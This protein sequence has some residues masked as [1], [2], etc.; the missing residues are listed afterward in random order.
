[1]ITLFDTLT[2]RTKKYLDY[3]DWVSIFK[4]FK[5]GFHYLPS[6]ENLVKRIVGQMNNNRLTNSGQPAT[7]RL[8]L[9]E[10][11]NKLLSL[12]SNYDVKEGKTW[13]ISKHKYL[14]EGKRKAVALVSSNSV[15]KTFNS[16][17]DCAKF[18]GVTTMTITSKLKLSQPVKVG[19]ESY[20]IN[21]V[22]F[23]DTNKI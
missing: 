22:D 21:K 4:I 17:T 20:I 2:F 13:I 16:I 7:N 3:S 14:G 15:F 1:M 10:E 9:I 12:P 11:I 19:D 23:Y 8:H 6:G 5:K 18:L